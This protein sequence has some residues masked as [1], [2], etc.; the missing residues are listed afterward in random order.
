[1]RLI[2]TN[3][4]IDFDSTLVK[5]E[6]LEELAKIVLSRNPLKEEILNKIVEITNKGMNGDITFQESLEQRLKLF[7]PSKGDILKLIDLLKSNI[8]DSILKNR[9]FFK[10]NNSHIYVISGGFREWIIPITEFVGL[11]TENVLANSFIYDKKG[12]VVGVD[13]TNILTR[14]KGKA[15][16]VQSLNLNGVTIMIGDGFTDY[17]VKVR[18]FSDKFIMFEEN[19]IREKV[20]KL[21]DFVAKSWDEVMQYLQNNRYVH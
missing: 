13:K 5:L 4:I 6:G 10:I 17:E 8:T 16:A 21:A 3:L 2:N 9:E 18:G 19:V 14:S 20:S 11:K 12:Y 15:M 7:S 1:M